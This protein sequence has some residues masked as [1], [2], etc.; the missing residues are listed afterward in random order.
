MWHFQKYSIFNLAEITK[1]NKNHFASNLN[2]PL[3]SRCFSWDQMVSKLFICTHVFV[4]VTVQIKG[5]P[6]IKKGVDDGGERER[7]LNPA[8]KSG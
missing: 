1:R 4:I 7:E 3:S 2:A 5:Q 8:K 6:H